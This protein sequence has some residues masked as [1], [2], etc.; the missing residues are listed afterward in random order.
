MSG[1]CQKIPAKG[2]ELLRPIE[3]Q[4]NQSPMLTSPTKHIPERALRMLETYGDD[5]NLSLDFQEDIRV[6]VVRHR[7][8][9]TDV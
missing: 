5:A 1:I 4:D 9:S 8:N 6:L 7:D 2:I 3:L